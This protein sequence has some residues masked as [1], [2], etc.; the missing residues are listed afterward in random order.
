MRATGAAA[1]WST[2]PVVSFEHPRNRPGRMPVDFGAFTFLL[3]LVPS[4][5]T[6]EESFPLFMGDRGGAVLRPP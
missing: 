2:A 3:F 6:P 5:P 1:R 4:P